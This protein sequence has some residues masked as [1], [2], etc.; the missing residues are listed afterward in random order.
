MYWS[1]NPTWG[2]AALRIIEC[3]LKLAWEIEFIP[4]LLCLRGQIRWY[5][6]TSTG[7]CLIFPNTFLVRALFKSKSG[8]EKVLCIEVCRAPVV[9]VVQ[10]CL[11][12]AA[13]CWRK[14][15][16]WSQRDFSSSDNFMSVTAGRANSLN[17][18]GCRCCTASTEDS[19]SFPRLPRSDLVW[20]CHSLVMHRI[21]SVASGS[22]A[23]LNSL[24]EHQS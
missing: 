14:T 21:A 10:H 1:R 17:H 7:M 12:C 20:S 13:F 8:E 15:I 18:S 4:F 9:S 16:W 19:L 2:R 3:F 24:G 11:Q 6:M 23:P 22:L 5:L